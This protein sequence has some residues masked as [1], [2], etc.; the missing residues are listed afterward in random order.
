VSTSAA[1]TRHRVLV[2]D[3]HPIVRQGLASVI[4]AEPD[5]VVCGEADGVATALEAFAALAPDVVVTDLSLYRTSGLELIK[6][7]KAAKEA[8]PIL[9]VSI[10]DE[11]VHAERALR[12][13]ASGYVMKE[14]ATTVIVSAIRRVLEGGVWVSDELSARMVQRYLRRDMPSSPV[15]GLSDREIEVFQMIGRG[16]ATRDIALALRISIK[17]VETHVAH[18]KDKLCLRNARELLQAATRWLEGRGDP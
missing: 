2:V 17:T 10:H 6:S 13:G 18:I 3:D 5:L 1:S 8:V 15:E 7:L 12:A 9:V 11:T 16:L 14:E 4:G